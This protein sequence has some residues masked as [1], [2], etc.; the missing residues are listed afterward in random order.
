MTTSLIPKNNYFSLNFDAI[1]CKLAVLAEKKQEKKL[2][3]V[4]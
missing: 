4:V 3:G 2:K 1:I